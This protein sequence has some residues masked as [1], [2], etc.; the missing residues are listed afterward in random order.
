MFKKTTIKFYTQ[1]AGFI[2]IKR[3]RL[4]ENSGKIF[5]FFYHIGNA[6]LQTGLFAGK[7][8]FKFGAKLGSA[9]S[10]TYQTTAAFIA[11]KVVS[12]KTVWAKRLKLALRVDF[13]KT[14]ALFGIF[15]LIGLGGFGAIRLIARGFEIKGKILGVSTSGADYLTQA[16]T[17]LDQQ[18]WEQA[19]NKFLLAYQSFSSGQE[20]LNQASR[21]LLG[22][23]SLVPQA[24]DADKIL[25]SSKLV[26][27]AGGE[28]VQATKAL[29]QL[30]FTAQGLSSSGQPTAEILNTAGNSL[31]SIL[32][33]LNAA[34]ENISQV[35]VKNF[36]AKDQALLLDMKTQL[37]IAANALSNFKDLFTLINRLI[38][39]KKNV[40]VLFENNNELRAGGGFMGTFGAF[41]LDNGTIKSSHISSIYDLDG[42]LQE[43]IIP[44]TPILNATDRWYLRDSNWFANFPDSAKTISNFYEKEGGETPDVILVLTPQI[45]IDLLK[46]TGPITLP[47]YNLTLTPDNFVEQTQVASTLSNDSPEN[48]PK[49][50]LADLFPALLQK[51]SALKASDLPILLE[52]LQANLNAKQIVLFARDQ[53]AQS[54]LEAFHWTGSLA[55]S[56]RDYLSVV[57]SNLGGTK[58]D[59]FIDQ[60]VDLQ[61]SI[62]DNGEITNQLTITRA[63]KLPDIRETDNDSFIRVFVPLGSS[64]IANSGFDYKDLSSV[65]AKNSGYKTDPL[66]FEWEKNSLRDVVS[67]TYIGQEA[68][69]TYFGNWLN[70]NGGQSKTITIT[71]KLPFSLKPLDRYSLLVQ[72]QIG[73]LE[74]NLNFK[75][76]FPGRAI[77]WKNF[78]ADSLETD[79]LTKNFTLNKDYFLGAVIQKR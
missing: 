52:D 17:A 33:A 54:Q 28:M 44:P 60:R 73:S 57:T 70:L 34:Q 36:P 21:S 4:E 76:Q 18:D 68:G 23:L 71:Y 22:L 30:R 12:T 5:L 38:L 65:E 58:T 8:I 69:K 42:Q 27:S 25:Q 43:K 74:Q 26:A 2:K 66:V 35:N 20:Q 75:L 55:Q 40:L 14:L 15:A 79:F 48:K 1:T 67:G 49:Q 46:L 32:K 3:H 37:S 13:A 29:N 11:K 16:K 72:K 6:V 56:D 63:N 61:S 19:S 31:N 62:N 24:N 7:N 51:I 64:L 78:D 50:V 53:N 45:I 10:K 47:T 41:S 9:V 59:L 77:A 39:G